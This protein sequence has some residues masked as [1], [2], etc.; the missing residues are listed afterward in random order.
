MTAFTPNNPFIPLYST[1]PR[2]DLTPIDFLVRLS[3]TYTATAL[4]VN[5][6]EIASFL[7]IE[8]P[9]GQIWDPGTTAVT[10]NDFR[11]GYRT[12]YTA[13]AI[14]APGVTTIPHGLT[15]IGNYSLTHIYGTLFNNNPG[16]PLFAP[17]TQPAPD[18]VALTVDGTNINIIAGTATYNG[19]SAIVVLEYLKQQ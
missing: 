11:G 12:V 16:A 6:R 3:Q 14:V 19:F 2:V 1:Y 8:T 5:A 17:M 7:K 10:V 13:A 4:A 9:T 15:N 18:Q